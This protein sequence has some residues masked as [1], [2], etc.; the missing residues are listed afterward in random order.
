MSTKK[1]LN[2]EETFVDFAKNLPRAEFIDE[3][4]LDTRQRNAEKADFF[5]NDRQIVCE[6][7]SLRT[8]Q[9]GKVDK[10]L[11][12][13]QQRPEWPI[14][15]GG[16]E[17]HKVLRHLPDGQQINK[18]IYD[19]VTSAIKEL[20]RKANR[21]IRTTKE[22][23]GLSSAGGLLVIL[24]EYVD[25]L[26]P[27]VIAQKVYELYNKRTPTGEPQFPEINFTWIINV[28]HYT[29]LTPDLQGLPSL[30]L[31][32]SVADLANVSDFIDSLQP[33]W[34]AY[35]GVPLIK[36]IWESLDSIKFESV[37]QAK[38][39]SSRKM[40]RHEFQ[41]MQYRQRPYLR[42]LNKE[43]MVEYGREL[44]SNLTPGFLKGATKRQQ[45]KTKLLLEPWTHFLEEINLRGMNMREFS[46]MLREL[47]E[48]I[49]A[50]EPIGDD[51]LSLTI[52]VGKKYKVGRNELC[53]C[54]S[55]RKYK[56]C[57]GSGST[58]QRVRPNLGSK[59]EV[60]MTK[61]NTQGPVTVEQHDNGTST[62]KI[63]F[64]ALSLAASRR[65]EH[66]LIVD[67]AASFAP[68]PINSEEDARAYGL[69]EALTR[70]PAK[71]GWEHRVEVRMIPLRFEFG[72]NKTGEHTFKPFVE[73]REV[74]D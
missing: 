24:N 33:Q 74:R 37:S 34:A 45:Q 72:K 12:P 3:L 35:N 36:A 5:F 66:D 44:M 49:N 59:P 56:K 40:V 1:P 27:D 11:R 8:D 15:Y 65:V 22:V 58:P 43:G 55:G 63:D 2:L 38:A 23:F 61:T 57:C 21:Q 51:Q 69:K 50:G 16:W 18:Q 54:E 47:G 32:N 41:R 25:I 9:M 20:V 10:I 26:S 7:K 30:I 52:P 62:V 19:G 70:W 46:P 60:R 68:A 28:S 39:S 14:F 31:P 42:A 67:H 64:Y 29:Q 17:I 48:K 73:R 6:L 4:K 71:D 13:H 53:P